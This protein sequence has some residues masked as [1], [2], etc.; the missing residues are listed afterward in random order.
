MKKEEHGAA[1]GTIVCAGFTR[2]GAAKMKFQILIKDTGV[3]GAH[4]E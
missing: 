1:D 2:P 4:V 3:F